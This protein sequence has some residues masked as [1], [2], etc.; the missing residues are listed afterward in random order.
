MKITN[1][2]NQIKRSF[3]IKKC[4]DCKYYYIPKINNDSSIYS[5]SKCM[6]FLSADTDARG[7]EFEYAYIVRSEK[8]MCG[9]DCKYFKKLQGP[10]T[11]V[12]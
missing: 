7:S 10:P 3:S 12:N 4:I 6:K 1:L 5:V 11:R 9:P 8:T 2:F